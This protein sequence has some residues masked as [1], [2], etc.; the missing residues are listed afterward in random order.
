MIRTRA[1]VKVVVARA[2]IEQVAAS[3]TDQASLCESAPRFRADGAQAIVD[4]YRE[5]GPSVLAGV[6]LVHQSN[7]FR[8]DGFIALLVGQDVPYEKR[9]N[10]PERER[11]F[12]RTYC[13]ALAVEAG[14]GMTVSEAL[15]AIRGPGLKWS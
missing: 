2:A 14:K 8:M 12:W 11:A 1:T 15:K 3:S 6:A 9:Y 10:P 5:N 4:W 13:Q 7:S